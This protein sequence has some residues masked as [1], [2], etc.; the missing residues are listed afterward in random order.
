LH[1]R[2]MNR[3]Q[4]IVTFL[5]MPSVASRD[6]ASYSLPRGRGEYGPVLFLALLAAV[7]AWHELVL[8]T[9]R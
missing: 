7:A 1:K 5:Q 4:V 6:R 2:N 9:F 3:K 8:L